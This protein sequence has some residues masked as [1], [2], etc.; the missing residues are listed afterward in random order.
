[1]KK[2]YLL[3][4]FAYLLISTSS[5]A[6]YTTLLNFESA[7][8]GT[9][10][11]GSLLSDGNF[12]YGMTSYGGTHNL[13]TIFKIMPNGTGYVKLL[14]FAG[15]SNGSLPQGA[16]ITDGN[17]LYGMTQQGGAN[18]LGT[19]FKITP[20][21]TGYVK[22]LDFAGATNGSYPNKTLF[23]DGTFL[24]GMTAAGG[25]YDIGTIF[26]IKPD[27]SNFVKL[28]DFAGTTNGSSPE[29]PLFSDGTFLYG[30]TPVGGTNNF[31]TIFKIMPDG[32]G[33]VRLLNFA[34]GSDGKTP[35]GALVSDGTF[36][37]GMTSYGGTNNSGTIFKIMPNGTGYAKLYD[38]GVGS[39]G[40]FPVNALLFDGVFLYGM[41]Q[42]GGTN[43]SGTMFTILP[44]GTG[45]VKLLD[46]EGTAN[47]SMPDGALISDGTFLY[48]TTTFGGTNDIGVVFKFG[49]TAGFAETNIGPE[50]MI[51]PNPTKGFVNISTAVSVVQ[52]VSITNILGEVVSS[53]EVNLVADSPVTIDISEQ[54]AGLYFLRVGNRVKKL[55]R[56]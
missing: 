55:I 56:Q 20:D 13:G 23:S 41:T 52:I 11:I 32:T 38:F 37:Y 21:G 48:G 28:L 54:Q 45:Y 8:S 14:D 4:A 17:Y 12:L 51:Y 2:I 53:Q 31:G 1:M 29:G 47:G 24:Y 15:A 35:R 10:P 3:F 7:T 44:D 6:Q 16:L 46:F 18:N 39:D 19:I 33:Y 30:M 9:Y 42:Q 25:T 43:D 36:L 50:F 40:S 27:G 22:L 26:K 49:M 34:G 5:Y